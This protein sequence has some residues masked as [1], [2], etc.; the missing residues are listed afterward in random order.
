[1]KSEIAFKM[2]QRHLDNL[3]GASTI[4]S[5]LVV[6]PRQHGKPFKILHISINWPKVTMSSLMSLRAMSARAAVKCLAF[7]KLPGLD[8]GR[9]SQ[10]GN[11][12]LQN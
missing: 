11:H 2:V 3:R 8:H 7:T 9:R 10:V 1:M 5:K 12:L 6:E 4:A